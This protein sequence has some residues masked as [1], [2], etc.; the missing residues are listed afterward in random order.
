MTVKKVD[1][2][3]TNNLTPVTQ[4]QFYA[5]INELS[6]KGIDVHPSLR[7]TG[8]PYTADWK[9]RDGTVVGVSKDMCIGRG[10][11]QYFLVKS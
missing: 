4:E 9:K 2:M 6:K 3:S 8:Y 1:P 7:R 11:A 10:D 5:R